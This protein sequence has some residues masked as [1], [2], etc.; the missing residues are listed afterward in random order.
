[1]LL[2]QSW[3][4]RVIKIFLEK[5]LKNSPPRVFSWYFPELK[6]SHR[7]Q[8][9]LAYRLKPFLYKTSNAFDIENH[10]EWNHRKGS[11]HLQ[12]NCNFWKK[13]SCLFFSFIDDVGQDPAILWR[14]RCFFVALDFPGILFLCCSRIF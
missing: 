7:E 11:N 3:Y 9:L 2:L 4:N 1:M 6:L 13:G 5:L 10:I 8:F 14:E 12:I